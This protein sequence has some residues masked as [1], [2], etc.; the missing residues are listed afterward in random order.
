MHLCD[1]T[2]NTVDETCGFIAAELFSEL[3]RFVDGRADRDRF[4]IQQLID[5]DTKDRKID[6]C[7]S[8]DRPVLCVLFDF[9]IDLIEMRMN[10][11]IQAI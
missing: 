9:R 4:F 7:D 3:D 8:S 11:L 10:P 1:R 2:E 5:G 6:L